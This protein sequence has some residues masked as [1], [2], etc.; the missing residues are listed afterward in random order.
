MVGIKPSLLAAS[1]LYLS[2]KIINRRPYWPPVLE[3]ETGYDEKEVRTLAKEYCYVLN[4]IS[5]DKPKCYFSKIKK[6][7]SS[8]KFF[9][10]ANIRPDGSIQNN[11]GSVEEIE[12]RRETSIT[13]ILIPT[14]AS[15]NLA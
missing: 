3:Q 8:A 4:E 9:E 2:K 12:R 13:G 15:T 11:S 14:T 7:F 10:V 1:A 5:K 6:K